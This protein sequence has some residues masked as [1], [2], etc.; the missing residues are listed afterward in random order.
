MK[1]P[2]RKRR[3]YARTYARPARLDSGRAYVLRAVAGLAFF[4]VIVTSLAYYAVRV[5][6]ADSTQRSAVEWSSLP[7]PVNQDLERPLIVSITVDKGATVKWQPPGNRDIL[8]YNLYRFKG[9]SDPGERVN[10][11]LILDNY[12]FDDNGTVVNL[13]SV[14]AVDRRGLEGPTSE[15]IAAVAEPKTLAGLQPT[16]PPEVM[17]DVTFTASA[18]PTLPPEIKDC[19]A[20]GM[21]YH[22]TW[23]LEHYPEVYGGGMMVTPYA[24]DNLTYTFE[25]S[26][27]GIISVRHWNY[28]IMHVYVDGELKGSADLYSDRAEAQAEVFAL[29]GLTPGVH[30]VK[31]ECSGLKNPA[32]NFTFIAVDAIKVK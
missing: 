12:Y 32:A 29:D 27:F 15:A 31:V 26:S 17:K 1:K 23:Y 5:R 10:A 7:K 22:G 30:T 9:D 8:G 19:T 16:A 18:A 14:A 4:T 2:K 20:P 13:Y 21:T 6:Q 28:G 11:A 25:G 3:G 24:G